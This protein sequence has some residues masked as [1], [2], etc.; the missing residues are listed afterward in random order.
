MSIPCYIINRTKWVASLWHMA[1]HQLLFWH[2][3]FFHTH[4]EIW[5][6]KW[7]SCCCCLFCIQN[8]AIMWI[9]EYGDGK[10]LIVSGRASIRGNAHRT[11]TTSMSGHL[12]WLR[13][14]LTLVPN[15][16]HSIYH[17]YMYM[18]VSPENSKVLTFCLIRKLNN[19]STNTDLKI[20][21]N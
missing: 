7:I 13:H 2:F 8:V 16:Y 12:S 4:A 1:L 10:K 19:I 21:S 18:Y 6:G 20:W 14:L 17:Y 11:L 9:L 5:A 15:L 3:Q